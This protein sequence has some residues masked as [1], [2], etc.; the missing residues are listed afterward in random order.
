MIQIDPAQNSFMPEN[1]TAIGVEKRRWF[2]L[3]TVA[4]FPEK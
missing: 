2:L 1:F 3:K 4:C